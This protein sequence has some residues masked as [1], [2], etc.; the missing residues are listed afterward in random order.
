MIY[1]INA[2]TLL[3]ADE[4]EAFAGVLARADM[5]V[6]DGVGAAWAVRKLTGRAAERVA[7]VDLIIDL[8]RIFRD[9]G[10]SVFL[11]GGRP[12]VAERA[13]R[14]LQRQM[15]GLAVAGSRDGF[16][17]EAE[18]E[19][20]VQAINLARPGL[21][22]A[23]LGQPQQEFFLDRHRD[24]LA[25]RVAM[26]VGGSFDVIAG[27]QRRAPRWLQ[28]LGLEWF[29]RML[30]EPW[31]MQRAARLPRFVWMIVKMKQAQRTQRRT[32]A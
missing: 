18:E 1:T 14:Q 11:L 7:G 29:Y 15:P 23:G 12:G 4:N 28:Q 20:V 3:L 8:C 6:A 5:A 27:D 32:H 10:Q 9:E 19:S 24:Q 16:W 22:L 2:L 17:A 30:Q 13:A 26:G 25:V 21:L 31:R